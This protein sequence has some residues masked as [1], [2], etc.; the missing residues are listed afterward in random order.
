MEE[1]PGD[2]DRR[3]F[4][5]HWSVAF[6]RD[7]KPEVPGQKGSGTVNKYALTLLDLSVPV[8]IVL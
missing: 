8:V 5:L 1:K 4:K 2:A 7:Y 6:W 3:N